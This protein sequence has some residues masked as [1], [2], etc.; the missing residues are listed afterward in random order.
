MNNIT[1][2]CICMMVL[3]VWCYIASVAILVMMHKLKLLKDCIHK[4]INFIDAR[5]ALIDDMFDLINTLN[6]EID[7]YS[8]ES[9]QDNSIDET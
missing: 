9:K 3:T 5:D 7:E 1:I 4:M 8:S 2:L 6:D